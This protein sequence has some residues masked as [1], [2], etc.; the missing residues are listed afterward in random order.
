M[1]VEKKIDFIKANQQMTY[2]EMKKPLGYKSGEGVRKFCR[3]HGITKKNLASPNPE[4]T[5]EEKVA[6]DIGIFKE[7]IKVRNTDKKYRF[8]LKKVDELQD[9]MEASEIIR[10]TPQEIIVPKKVY[11]KT[12]ATFVAVYSDW[13]CEEPVLPA[14]VN[15][16]NEYN[17]KI[18]DYRIKNFFQNTLR[19]IQKEQDCSVI[20]R[21]VLA[22]LGDFISGSIHPELMESSLLAPCEA[23][24]WV[25]ARIVSGINFLLENTDLTFDVIMTPGNHGRTTAK[26]RHATEPGNSLETL[27]YYW[28]AQLFEDNKRLNFSIAEGY[29]TYY[30]PFEDYTIRFHHGHNIR[31]QGGVAGIFIPVYKAI[32]KWN[33]AKYANLDIFA[34]FHQLKD[35]GSFLVNGSGIGWNGYALS[36]KAS[37][38]TP[39]QL[40][41]SIVRGKG[42]SGVYPIWAC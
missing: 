21:G 23:I 3:N 13:H 40:F 2:D 37:Y 9:L 20:K 15:G 10:H 6:H 7:K 24:R 11:D 32:M 35:G 12:D 17:L 26:I 16:L 14:T 42:K 38:E 34:H 39:R 41:V 5:T 8:L 1:T 25:Q 19:L 18:A 36:I 31:Y 22:F 33:E 27:M 4:L 28:I 30:K 29:L